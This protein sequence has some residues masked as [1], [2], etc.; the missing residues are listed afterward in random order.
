[1]INAEIEA[2]ELQDK[3]THICPEAKIDF[4][5]PA[6]NEAVITIHNPNGSLPVNIFSNDFDHEFKVV[7]FKT[8][9]F[10]PSN[11]DGIAALLKAISDYVTGKIVYMDII[12]SSNNSYP[13]DRL[14]H[15]EELPEADLDQ[16]A[17]LCINKNLLNESELRFELQAGSSV[18]INFWDQT[19]NFCYK[20]QNGKIIKE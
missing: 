13:R 9:R 7:Y 1:M 3:L 12:S 8:P 4:K 19:K 17:R 18:C 6:A 2:R 10:F 5:V 20:M 16:L 15:V 14:V 11:Q